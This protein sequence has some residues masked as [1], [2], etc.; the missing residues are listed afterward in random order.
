MGGVDFI[1]EL[2]KLDKK[3]PVFVV[4]GYAENSVMKN[5]GT[6][7]FTASISKPFAIEDL[8]QMLNKY[9]SA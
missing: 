5:P 3:I 7:G 8:S 2:R 6:Y 4:S 9:I 1:T